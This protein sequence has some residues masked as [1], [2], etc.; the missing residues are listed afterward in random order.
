MPAWGIPISPG[1]DP[2]NS[3]KAKQGTAVIA[4]ISHCQHKYTAWTI[5]PFR[6]GKAWTMHDSQS[7]LSFYYSHPFSLI[8]PSLWQAA[9]PCSFCDTFLPDFFIT[10]TRAGHMPKCPVWFL[11]LPRAGETS[12]AGLS[13]DWPFPCVWDQNKAATPNSFGKIR[14]RL[15]WF[16]G[17]CLCW[18]S[19]FSLQCTG[20]RHFLPRSICTYL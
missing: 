14:I 20:N 9:L 11:H 10:L 5:Q 13:Q 1:T 12:Q 2:P 6:A 19:S 16:H 4:E 17:P 3:S 15:T 8:I 18:F 7:A